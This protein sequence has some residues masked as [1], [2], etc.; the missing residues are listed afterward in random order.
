MK[1][2]AIILVFFLLYSL[3]DRKT[4]GEKWLTLLF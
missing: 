4:I 2:F 1:E 3:P